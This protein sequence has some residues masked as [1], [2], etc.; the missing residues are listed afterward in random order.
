MDFCSAIYIPLTCSFC[1]QC[2]PFLI[3]NKLLLVVVG[4]FK[5]YSQQ[6]LN[7]FSIYKTRIQKLG[8]NRKLL[9]KRKKKIIHN[10]TTTQH[11]G[12]VL[13]D[14]SAMCILTQMCWTE[15][16]KLRIPNF[17]FYSL[18]V[19]AEKKLGTKFV[20]IPFP[21]WLQISACLREFSCDVE[22]KGERR[23]IILLR[24]LQSDAWADASQRLLSKLL[25]T[26]CLCA[27][28]SDRW[29]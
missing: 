23:V 26:S 20:R 25:S 27:L 12:I 21:A 15:N 2:Y 29:C 18:P 17:L 22:G 19:T 24:Q 1:D 7:Y 4:T 6:I 5:F 3:K 8:K 28:C 13:S 9:K 16:Y 14:F 10:S 11:F